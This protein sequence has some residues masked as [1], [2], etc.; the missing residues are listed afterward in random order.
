MSWFVI[1]AIALLVGWAIAINSAAL[2]RRDPKV[3]P[4]LATWILFALAQGLGISTYFDTQ[5]PNPIAYSGAL[6][7]Y[8]D[9][10]VTL[11]LLLVLGFHK[12]RFTLTQLICM[13]LSIMIAIFWLM[14]GRAKESNY[15]LQIIMVLGYIPTVVR[16]YNAE[17]TTE[18]EKVWWLRFAAGVFASTLSVAALDLLAIAYCFRAVASAVLMIYLIRRIHRR[19]TRTLSPS[20]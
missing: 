8:C 11:F 15:L 1:A 19:A 12:I 3:K 16:L 14:T 10:V 4:V 18:N 7:G 17:M 6:I 13:G 2:V 20:T 9:V 5:H